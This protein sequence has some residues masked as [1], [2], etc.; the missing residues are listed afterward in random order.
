[1]FWRF[2]YS[3]L[4]GIILFSF[5]HPVQAQDSTLRLKKVIRGGLT[6]KS[7]VHSG[8]GL[9]FAQNMMYS[10]TV[11][12]YNREY[13]LVKTISDKVK[14]KDFGIDTINGIL[15]GSPVE[16]AFS[17]SGKYAWV[18]NYNMSGDKFINPGCDGCY[19]DE[20]DNSYLYKI[21]TETFSIEKII[22]VG[23]VPKY[24]AVSPD[25]KY[26]L[27][28]N[29][30]SGDVSIVDIEQSREIKRVKAGRFPRGIVVDSKSKYAYVTIMG[31][32][33]VL[34]IDLEDFTTS[35]IKNVGSGP[36]HLCISSDD[37]LLY[38]SLNNEGKIAR[39][40][41]HD[42]SIT[43]TICG[44]SP[45]SMIITP[46]DKFL[47][48]VNYSIN[49]MSKVDLKK[50]EVT[51]QQDTKEHPIGI[52]FDNENNEVWVA[53]Y[54]GSLMVY[55]DLYYPG[56]SEWYEIFNVKDQLA[57]VF[58]YF[59]KM[60]DSFFAS[61]DTKMT[62]VAKAKPV[63][64]KS[65]EKSSVKNEIVTVTEKKK[66]ES[67]SKNKMV[68]ENSKPET[69]NP[70]PETNVPTLASEGNIFVIVG[71]FK[72]ESNATRLTSNLVAKGY[73]ATT[74]KNK[75]G[76]TYAAIGGFK[77]EEMANDTLQK[78]KSKEGMDAWIYK[79]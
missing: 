78:I 1:M 4:F 65:E 21:N 26:V 61:A 64:K 42:E 40:N 14:P 55:R 16:A 25:N 28:S 30:S 37:S 50:F 24:V 45:R 74:I 9:F 10:H 49:K 5:H 8:N 31:S 27:V 15:N 46:D 63:S 76:M 33:H 59:G 79:M 47:Y 39:I 62:V 11:R 20:Y 58:D 54:S 60:S 73:T 7:V 17:H 29:W 43:K 3:F 56:G 71:S 12:V 35:Q 66:S 48:V 2:I 57:S 75:N 53:C 19:S 38:V 22:T 41:L 51:E 72:V 69:P 34:K 67:V 68:K 52:T 6:P 44:G 13:E 18:S 32:I 23:S 70:K 77:S 36:R